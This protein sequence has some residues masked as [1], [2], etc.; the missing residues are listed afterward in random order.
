LENAG[1][2]QRSKKRIFGKN[3]KEENAPLIIKEWPNLHKGL[4]DRNLM[5]EKKNS[6][7]S[8]PIRLKIPNQKRI[9]D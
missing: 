5:V 7:K 2:N 8:L 4:I 3:T 9:T 1:I 6:R